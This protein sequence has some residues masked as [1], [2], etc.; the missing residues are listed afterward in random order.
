[1]DGV[2][3]DDGADPLEEGLKVLGGRAPLLEGLTEGLT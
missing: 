2:G 1:M 3:E